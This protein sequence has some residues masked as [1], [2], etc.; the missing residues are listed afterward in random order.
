MS[1]VYSRSHNIRVKDGDGKWH[2]TSCLVP[3]ADFF[4]TG[5]TNSALNVDCATNEAS[6]HFECRATKAIQA[7]QELFAP[8]GGRQT[9]LRNS[10]LLT[11]YGFT[12]DA[13]VAEGLD[14]SGTATNSVVVPEVVSIEVPVLGGKRF[15]VLRYVAVECYY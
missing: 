2:D 13:T 3:L 4:N 9:R 8:Y 6:T 14:G 1:D 5:T 10:V 15:E 11:E 7:G 12:L